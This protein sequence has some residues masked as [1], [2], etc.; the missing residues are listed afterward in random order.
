MQPNCLTIAETSEL[1]LFPQTGVSLIL[2]LLEQTD[3]QILCHI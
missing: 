3:Q 2:I 1:N